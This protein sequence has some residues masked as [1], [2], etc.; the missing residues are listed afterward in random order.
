MMDKYL[1]VYR[2]VLEH[3]SPDFNIWS[4]G[5]LMMFPLPY[6]CGM[7]ERIYNFKKSQ[8]QFTCVRIEPTAHTNKSMHRTARPRY[9]I[10]ALETRKIYNYYTF[11][12]LNTWLV[13][14]MTGRCEFSR[15]SL[16]CRTAC[17][18]RNW[19]ER[20]WRRS[21]AMQDRSCSDWVTG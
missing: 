15:L 2:V 1:F 19:P 8:R 17:T 13:Q 3:S 10:S 20:R 11:T 6:A 21:N 16:S 7:S 14:T 18:H 5:L 9:D 12:Y 4:P